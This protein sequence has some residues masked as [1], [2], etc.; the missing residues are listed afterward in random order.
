VK[1]SNRILLTGT[2][3][4]N[5][6]SELFCM[7][8]FVRPNIWRKEQFKQLFEDPFKKGSNKD[9]EEQQVSIL[10]CFLFISKG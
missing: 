8:D 7:L 2:P 6:F 1:T 5:R 4:Q 9:S 3:V 10:M